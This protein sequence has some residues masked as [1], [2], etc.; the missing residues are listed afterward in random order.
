MSARAQA[1]E[2]VFGLLRVMQGAAPN[3][4]KEWAAYDDAITAVETLAAGTKKG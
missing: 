2:N 4:S 3:L 1:F